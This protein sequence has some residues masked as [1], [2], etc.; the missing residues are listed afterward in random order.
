MRRAV[1]A[2]AAGPGS[3]S[4]RVAAAEKPFG[5]LDPDSELPSGGEQALYHRIASTI[6]SGGDEDDDYEEDESYDEAAAIAESIA[7][8]DEQRLLLI[9]RDMLRLYELLGSPPDLTARW[10]PDWPAE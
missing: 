6:V 10:P 5:E 8:L 9:A 7:A 1:D 3:L 2:L 4:A